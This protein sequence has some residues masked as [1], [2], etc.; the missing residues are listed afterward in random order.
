M[1]WVA[2]AGGWRKTNFAVEEQIR[3]EIRQLIHQGNGLVSGGALGV[4]F[5]ATDEALSQ[6]ISVNQLK[7]ILP[8]TLARYADHYLQRAR[9]EVITRQQAIQLISQLEQVQSMGC[10]IEG[11]FLVIDQSAYF[12][13]ISKII[14]VAD[15]LI[16]FDINQTAGTQDTIK[17]AQR[18][19]IPVK[20][21]SYSIE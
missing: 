13:R 7:I 12:N 4:D 2:V 5:I 9:E 15:E 21:F 6:N 3:T 8:S 11:D 14:D 1:K 17:K 18:K 16:A 19:G 20:I 10:L